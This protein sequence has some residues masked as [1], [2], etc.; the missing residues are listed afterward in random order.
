M[1]L[2]HSPLFQLRCLCEALGC[3]ITAQDQAQAFK[4]FLATRTWEQLVE[5]LSQMSGGQFLPPAIDKK[6]KVLDAR[7]KKQGV[8]AECARRIIAKLL[9]FGSPTVPVDV[10]EALR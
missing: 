6:L 3:T 8:Y 9:S 10:L 2:P 5:V 4:M 7:R 1:S